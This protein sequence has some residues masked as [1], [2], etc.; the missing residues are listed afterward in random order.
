MFIASVNGNILLIMVDI[1][2]FLHYNSNGGICDDRKNRIFGPAFKFP[3]Q[4]TY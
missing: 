3:G 4:T 1:L 2:A